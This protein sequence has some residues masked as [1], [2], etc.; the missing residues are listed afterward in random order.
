MILLAL[1]ISSRDGIVVL[2]GVNVTIPSCDGYKPPEDS[3]D[4]GYE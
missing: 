1:L 4:A 2:G 3:L